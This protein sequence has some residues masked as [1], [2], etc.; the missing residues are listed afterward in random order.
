MTFVALAIVLFVVSI[1]GA[2]TQL[3]YAPYDPLE[4]AFA[5]QRY[6]NARGLNAVRMQLDLIEQMKWYSGLPAYESGGSVYRDPPSL[7]YI[8][9]MGRRRA[10]DDYGRRVW[11]G[12]P[13]IFEPWP[14]VPGDIWGYQWYVPIRQPIGRV[15][16]QTSPNRWESHPLY[17]DEP[18]RLIEVAPS[19]DV[20][21]P[22]PKARGPRQF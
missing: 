1:A 21:S 15:E 12:H 18:P 19:A 17:V 6:D 8:Y 5:A 22:K 14:Y 4:A 10:R 20:E 3:Y 11:P 16:I 7:D 9:A 2:E 13:D